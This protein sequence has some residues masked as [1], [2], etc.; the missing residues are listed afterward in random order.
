V[1]GDVLVI[2]YGNTLRGDDG[3]GPAVAEAV[4]EMGLPGV[5]V[6]VE[7][8]LTPELA[9]DLAESRLT[10]FVDAAVG[11]KA[12]T[13]VRLV[14]ATAGEVMTH[15]VDPSGLLALALAAYGRTPEAWLVTAAGA[16]FG[17]RDGLSPTGTGNA[18]EALGCVQ[19]LIQEA[20]GA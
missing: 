6:L 17:F 1:R 10:V 2:G 11:D 19:H 5:R 20:T 12:V 8:Q 4:V 18:L 9:A 16:D 13:A 7:H 3:I 15:A 14:A